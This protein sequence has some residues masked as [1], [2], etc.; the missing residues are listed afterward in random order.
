MAVEARV[1]HRGANRIEP[2]CNR[3]KTLTM[4]HTP[5]AVNPLRVT[6]SHAMGPT[7]RVS[8]LMP[9]Y[10]EAATVADSIA[11]VRAV[12]FLMEIICVDDCSTDGTIVILEEMAASD[13]RISLIRHPVNRGKGAAV[14]APRA[15][16]DRGLYRRAVRGLLGGQLRRR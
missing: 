15:Q 14:W 7:L 4:L 3:N 12:P 13:R 10:N 1:D 16:C 2:P 6:P 9:V 8:V 11:R 5:G